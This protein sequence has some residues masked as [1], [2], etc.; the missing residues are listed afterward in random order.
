MGLEILG[1]QNLSYKDADKVNNYLIDGDDTKVSKVYVPDTIPEFG[2]LTPSQLINFI[3]SDAISDRLSDKYN[4]D[5][6]DKL[7]D[8]IRNMV[9]NMITDWKNEYKRRR[10]NG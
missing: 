7:L 6:I 3:A 2:Y 8:E 5:E 1:V 10:L 4:K 9:R